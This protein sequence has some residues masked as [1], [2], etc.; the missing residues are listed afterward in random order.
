MELCDTAN[1]H[2]ALPAF[3]SLDQFVEDC[4]DGQPWVAA[5]GEQVS[6]IKSPANPIRNRASRDFFRFHTNPRG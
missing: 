1:A 5:P 6:D 2:R 3:T 4:G